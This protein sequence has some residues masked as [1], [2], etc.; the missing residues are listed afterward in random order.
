MYPDG[1]LGVPTYQ[2]T[3]SA[4]ETREFGITF[5]GDEWI[6]RVE[7]ID[8]SGNIVFSQDYVMPDMEKIG[9]KIV[10][11]PLQN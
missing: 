11:P 5:L 6:I 3:I 4:N 10:I 9:W 2:K 7:A 8:P 1:T